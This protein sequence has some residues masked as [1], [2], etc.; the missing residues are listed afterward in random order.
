VWLNLTKNNNN[1]TFGKSS[2]DGQEKLSIILEPCTGIFEETGRDMKL[3]EILYPKP[4]FNK[5]ILKP[6]MIIRFTLIDNRDI[7]DDDIFTEY[8]DCIGYITE[9]SDDYITIYNSCGLQCAPLIIDIEY[10]FNDDG[11]PTDFRLDIRI[12]DEDALYKI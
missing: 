8:D 11:T 4:V 5:N 6:G 7:D 1:L 2:E 12:I 9:V 3:S 10:L